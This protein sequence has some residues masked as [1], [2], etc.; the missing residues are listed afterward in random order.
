M[1]IGNNMNKLV[2]DLK[3]LELE[4]LKN[5]RN[6]KSANTLR[7]YESDYKDFSAFCAKNNF[8]SLPA[9]P[10]I[11]SLY[12][13]HLSHNSKFSTLK[14]RIASI[15]VIH[16]LKGYY[17]DTKHPIIR[18]NLLGIKRKKGSNQKA[19]KPILI[20]DLKMIINTI[21]QLNIREIR[22]VRDK[23]LILI[24]FAGGF[25]RSELVALEN[26]DIEF[27]R[28]GV[29]IFVKRSMTDQ[30]G[31]GMTKAIP[32]FDNALYCPVL[33]LQDWMAK[34]KSKNKKVFPISDK[35]VAL[36]IKKYADLA[37]LDGSKYAGH[38]LRSGFAT[39][40]AESGAEER[41]I[42]AMTG[43]KTTQ[44]V[45]RYIHE[46]NLFKNNALNKIKI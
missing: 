38:S 6:S 21:S 4:T 7:A 46:A 37:G 27:V 2:T 30:S 34:G 41:N 24:G 11:L 29:K 9:D 33:H 10:K 39:S 32:S 22:Q 26:D 20:N 18:E 40:T 44:M 25:R 14:R 45:R 3:N 23:A 42:M 17:I 8:S 28:E 1:V 16:K 5:L 19:K 13:T 35:S 43:H 15:S 36:I 12:L 31:E